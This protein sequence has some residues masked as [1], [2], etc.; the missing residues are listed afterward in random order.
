M[1]G[2]KKHGCSAESPNAARRASVQSVPLEG[3]GDSR[4]CSVASRKASGR[5][6]TRSDTFGYVIQKMLPTNV[7]MSGETFFV[8]MICQTKLAY[9][10]VMLRFFS[11]V[12][13]LLGIFHRGVFGD[14]AWF[15]VVSRTFLSG[16]AG[17]NGLELGILCLGVRLWSPIPSAGCILSW[18]IYI[19]GRLHSDSP[20]GLMSESMLVHGGSTLAL[21]AVNSGHW[22]TRQ[23]SLTAALGSA[24]TVP[25]NIYRA[26]QVP[27]TFEIRVQELC[28]Q[29]LTECKQAVL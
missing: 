10:Y 19:W 3:Y 13:V 9:D 14:P 17:Y 21:A 23:H 6:N 2:T 1:A 22:G 20:T 16:S 28:L 11:S 27:V 7:D 15:P 12:C 26:W 29:H 5:E 4:G 18:R 25:S 24:A 8:H